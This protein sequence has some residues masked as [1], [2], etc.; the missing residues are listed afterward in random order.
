MIFKK[1]ISIH[2][3]NTISIRKREDW[4]ASG[5]ETMKMFPRY[6]EWTAGEIKTIAVSNSFLTTGTI[7]PYGLPDTHQLP[8]G[9]LTTE[10]GITLQLTDLGIPIDS[11]GTS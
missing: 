4:V 2:E 11:S 9:T 1:H 6:S 3:R 10:I 8:P 7:G 5:K